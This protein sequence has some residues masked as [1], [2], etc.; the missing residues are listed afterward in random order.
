MAPSNECGPSSPSNIFDDLDLYS[1][2]IV[3]EYPHQN[4]GS[5]LVLDVKQ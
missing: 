5:T 4:A 3:K 2:T 1:D